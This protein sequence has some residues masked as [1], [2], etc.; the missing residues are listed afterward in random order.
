MKLK[1]HIF[2]LTKR[3]IQKYCFLF[4]ASIET[5][6][7][8]EFIITHHAH[9]R[10]RERVGVSPEKMKKLVMKAWNC[11]DKV[12]E[13]VKNHSEYHYWY[14][15]GKRTDL[16]SCMGYIFIFEKKYLRGIPYPQ[17]ILITVYR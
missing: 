5:D 7:P 8:P 6:L 15:R 12:K 17:K 16:R 9:Q 11:R 1:E 10:M 3:L 4:G 2:N 13:T 14:M